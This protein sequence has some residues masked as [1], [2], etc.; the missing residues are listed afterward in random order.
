[1]H[2][3]PSSN[4]SPKPGPRPNPDNPKPHLS[5]D[6]KISPY[7]NLKLKPNPD[8]STQL[9]TFFAIE[10]FIVNFL[11]FLDKRFIINFLSIL[12]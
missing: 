1:M 6:L 11:Q 12:L 4:S 7:Q 10:F 3:E 5:P 8:P 2:S 9:L